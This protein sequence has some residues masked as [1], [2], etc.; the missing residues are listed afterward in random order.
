M[1]PLIKARPVV[2]GSDFERI[3]SRVDLPQPFL[4]SRR[5]HHLRLADIKQIQSLVGVGSW[6]RDS[7]D[8][9]AARA[10]QRWIFLIQHMPVA[11]I[12]PVIGKNGC[13]N[14]PCS[15]SSRGLRTRSRFDQGAACPVSGGWDRLPCD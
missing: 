6:P 12:R 14:P 13:A 10:P 9:H 7:R 4:R 3:L 2:G 15:R 5:R 1:L 11:C 8:R